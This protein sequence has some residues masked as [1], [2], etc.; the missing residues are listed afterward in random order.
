MLRV[1]IRPDAQTFLASRRFAIVAAECAG[2][3]MWVSILAGAPGFLVSSEDGTRL[4][5]TVLPD[6]DDPI[7][8]AISQESSVGLLVI[9]FTARRR[10]R[11]NGVVRSVEGAISLDVR[12]AF[13]NC[14]K[15]IHAYSKL[16]DEPVAHV[17]PS[18]SD[19]LDD[20][21]RRWI[22]T[23]ETLF[24]GTMHPDAGADAS[25]RGGPAGF[26][27]V[28]GPRTL[29]WGDY[30]GNKLFQSLGNTAVHPPAGLLFLDP[31]T[32]STLQLT[33]TL[34]IDWSPE[35]AASIPGA[36][37][38]LRFTID[39]VVERSGAI[40]LRWA[41]GVSSPANPPAR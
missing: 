3:R 35:A 38:V 39:Q 40:P 10:Y 34:E 41:R 1:A 8:G 28:T 21:Q 9:S 17:D 14:S 27:R 30:K 25:H 36:E 15:Y 19:R 24:L 32:G 4:D 26:V 2:G 5:V 29:V 23:T 16:P 22:E 33:G 37:R 11:V 7:S 12:E 13:S 20:R 6:L 31:D 18:T